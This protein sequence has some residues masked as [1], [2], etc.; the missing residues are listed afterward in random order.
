MPLQKLIKHFNWEKYFYTIECSDSQVNT[1][2]KTKMIKDIFSKNSVFKN[3]LFVGDTIGD[4]LAAHR[5]GIR[6]VC[7]KYG[8]G[9]NQDW[10]G[11]EVF[12]AIESIK[13]CLFIS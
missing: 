3:S 9:N 7:A 2:D 10:S 11:I 5:S 1:R 8:Y 13:E 6:F 4:A 12:I